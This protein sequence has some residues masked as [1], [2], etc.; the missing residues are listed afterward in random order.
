MEEVAETVEMFTL[1]QLG[2]WVVCM[3]WEEH[4]SWE[5]MENTEW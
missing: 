2:D 4:I 5:T 1:D 3:I